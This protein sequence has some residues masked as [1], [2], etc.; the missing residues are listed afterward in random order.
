MDGSY[1]PHGVQDGDI[2]D[3]PRDYISAPDLLEPESLERVS[4]LPRYPSGSEP[5]YKVRS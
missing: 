1:Q 2:D 3:Q 4:E 5:T